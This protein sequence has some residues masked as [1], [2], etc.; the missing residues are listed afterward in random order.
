MCKIV[1]NLIDINKQ[2]YWQEHIHKIH[3]THPR[4][5]QALI[6]SSRDGNIPPQYII[7]I[8]ILKTFTDKFNKPLT[9]QSAAQT[10]TPPPTPKSYPPPPAKWRLICICAKINFWI[11]VLWT[12]WACY[13]RARELGYRASDLCDQDLQIWR[14][15]RRRQENR[16]SARM[17]SPWPSLDSFQRPRCLH[18]PFSAFHEFWF[19]KWIAVPF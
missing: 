13:P 10:Q 6:L 16:Q 11:Y 18:V 7:E 1:I 17:T 19:R 4:I 12:N 2:E 9:K 3:T 14:L 15:T 5:L 8:R